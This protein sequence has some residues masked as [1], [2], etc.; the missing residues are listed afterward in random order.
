MDF[1]SAGNLLV[2]HHGSE[3]IEVFGP[4]GG[5]PFCR[6]K[7]PFKTPSNVHFRPNTKEV[8]VTEHDTHGLWMFEWTQTGAKQY[9]DLSKS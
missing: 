2:A 9:C 1:D 4:E 7:C 6:I 5:T 8:Y 3:H